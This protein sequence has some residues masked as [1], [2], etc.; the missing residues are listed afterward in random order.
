MS[1]YVVERAVTASAIIDSTR[2]TSSASGDVAKEGVCAFIAPGLLG[3]GIIGTRGAPPGESDAGVGA[4]APASE[5]AELVAAVLLP[6][7]GR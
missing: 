2:V 3:M 1:P 7:V 5:L 6:T 4:G